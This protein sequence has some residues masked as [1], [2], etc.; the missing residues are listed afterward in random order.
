MELQETLR[1]HNY[2][3]YVEAQPQIGDQEFDA[4]LKELADLEALHPELVTP[5]SPTQRVGGSPIDG[6]ESVTHR[7]PMLSLDNT[8][9]KDEVAEFDQRLKRRVTDKSWRYVVE[10]KIDGVAVNL[11]Y[12][13]GL[14]V[15][16]ASRGDGQTGDDITENVKTIRSIP[17]RLNDQNLAVPDLLEVRGELYMSNSGFV[18]LNEK[19]QAE[20]LPAFVNPRNAAAGSLKLLDPREVAQRPLDGILYGVGTIE[21]AAFD[22]H[23]E[24]LAG[25]KAWGFKTHDHVW[26]SATLAEVQ[27]A[28]DEIGDAQKAHDY[29]MDGAVI[30]VNERTLYEELGYTAKSPRWAVA[31]KYAAEQ[32]ETTLKDITIQVGR[33][34][35]L[36]P[37]AELEP[38]FVSGTTVSRA[39]L[40]NEEEIQR[41]D[42]RI[43]DRVVIE[44]AGEIIPAVVKVLLEQRPA[45]ARQFEMPQNCPECSSAVIRPEGEVAVRC[46]NLQC[47]AQIKNWVKHF[48]SRK[49][50]DIEGLGDVLVEQLVDAGLINDPSD[51]YKL[52]LEQLSG[53]E[54]MGEKSAE[55]VLK[56][57]ELSKT[58]EL[59]RLI[60]ALGI[61]HVG[62]GSARI[63]AQNF[64]SLDELQ[65]ALPETL[66]NLND[67]GPIV[68]DSIATFLQEESTVQ[69][70]ARLK[71]AG[72]NMRAEEKG[73]NEAL[74]NQPMEG[75]TVVLTGSLSSHTRDEAGEKL[76]RLGAKVSGSVSAKT[77]VLV[78]GEKA[79]SKR[80]KAETLGIEIW[81]EQQM[82]T[83]F[84]ENGI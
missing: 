65:T 60:H 53:L 42:I 10:P 18:T 74:G 20:G 19:R 22:T 61:R 83:L 76:I 56:G 2:L 64:S 50:M 49:A 79:G 8:Y 4:L 57:I 52:K 55:N 36:T 51:L 23:E 1:R 82:L 27:A 66:E 7:S 54:R 34:G 68:A 45:D 30:K 32:A 33:T 80:K 48:A 67:I 77:H 6:F 69:I 25:L 29:D 75:K 63:L 46:P 41:K 28:I 39:T 73:G 14:L 84:E 16:A 21:G 24:L 9:S 26:N 72:L 12:E 71:E 59:W 47:P 37:V 3:Y 17:L 40:H 11:T 31:Y 13:K 15:L 81:D 44:K 70:L 5:D 43:G 58:R 78:A 38:V 62:V 35:V